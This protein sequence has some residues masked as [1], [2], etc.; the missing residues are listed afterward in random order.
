MFRPYGLKHVYLEFAILNFKMEERGSDVM[1]HSITFGT[2]VLTADKKLAGKNTWTDW[3]LIPSSRPVVAQAPVQTNF[4]DIPGRRYGPIDMSEYLT[5]APIYGQ[6][7]GSFEFIVDNDHEYWMTIQMNI[8][9]Y[10]HG[11]SMCMVLE[12]DPDYYY[13]GRFMLNDWKNESWNSKVVINYILRPYKERLIDI[14]NPGFMIWDP[15]N[16][17]RDRTDQHG[18]NP[19]WL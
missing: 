3:H 19:G 8:A 14:E 17:D 10:L 16:F 4:V 5:G 7:N 18:T 6:R 2:G 13:V 9:E 12:D 15:F 1:Y 11:K